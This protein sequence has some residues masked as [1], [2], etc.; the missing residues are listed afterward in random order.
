VERVVHERRIREVLLDATPHSVPALVRRRL[1]SRGHEPGVL[2]GSADGVHVEIAV[3]HPDPTGIVT[4]NDV[5][6]LALG[7]FHGTFI[8][9]PRPVC[10]FLSYFGSTQVQTSEKRQT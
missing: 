1:L 10:R 6:Q 5:Q 3:D 7:V 2:F 8:V 4:V 9:T